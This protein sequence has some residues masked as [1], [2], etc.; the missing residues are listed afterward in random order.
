MHSA[1]ILCSC[2]IR[3]VLV[4]VLCWCCVRIQVFLAFL[5]LIDCTRIPIRVVFV[6]YSCLGFVF[7]ICLGVVWYRYCII[8]ELESCSYCIRIVFVLE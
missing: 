8:R 6:L 1:F 3:S 5:W 4:L 2:C 7:V